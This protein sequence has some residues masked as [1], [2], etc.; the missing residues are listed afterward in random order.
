LIGVLRD[1]N[2]R[3]GSVAMH[4][5]VSEGSVVSIS[6][7]RNHFPLM[8][9]A[10]RSLLLAGGIGVTPILCMAERLAVI[11]ADFE[12]HYCTRSPERTA[13]R[14]RILSS[15]FND[16][17]HFYYDD[18]SEEQKLHLTTLFAEPLP[19]KHLYV[20]GP[21]GFLDFV[22]STA[23]ANGWSESTIHFEYFSSKIGPSDADTAFDVK[24]ASSGKI[25]RVPMGW[26]ITK[27]LAEAGVEIPM[28]CEQGVCGTCLTRVLE[29]EPDHRDHFLTDAEKG[30]NDQ[31]LPC[32]SR[33][34]SPVLILDL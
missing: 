30:K 4:D 13:F 10:R 2:S 6:E 9:N 29:G 20:C 33:S 7:P 11:G 19:D 23:K 12:M 16:K 21:G 18:G 5:H 8:H 26:P 34:K 31:M 17:V 22:I 24:V 32:C 14:S 15:I 25:V 1:A 3:G 28:S 27:A